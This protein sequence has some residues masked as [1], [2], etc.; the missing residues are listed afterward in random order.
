MTPVQTRAEIIRVLAR[1]ITT[2]SFISSNNY[3]H[4]ITYPFFDSL[5]L[6]IMQST[7]EWIKFLDDN[8]EILLDKIIKQE[9]LLLR[10]ANEE[11]KEPP[12]TNEILYSLANH[13]LKLLNK[14]KLN[15]VSQIDKL[16]KMS[17]QDWVTEMTE[18]EMYVRSRSLKAWEKYR[19]FHQ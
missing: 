6:L 3:I 15:L 18:R 7:S 17:H 9:Q 13:D 12:V 2:S 5:I 4:I 19:E 16:H 11:W 1:I 8:L 10:I 14:M